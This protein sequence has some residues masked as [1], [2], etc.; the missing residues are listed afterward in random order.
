MAGQWCSSFRNQIHQD[1]VCQI[2]VLFFVQYKI[3]CQRRL[4]LA[5]PLYGSHLIL[6]N[7]GPNR[8]TESKTSKKSE[9]KCR[10][11]P[12]RLSMRICV[13]STQHNSD[14]PVSKYSVKHGRHAA[15]CTAPHIVLRWVNPQ[16]T[17]AWFRSCLF[18]CTL[19]ELFVYQSSYLSS[20]AENG[21]DCEGN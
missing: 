14:W 7:G 13:Y 16:C 3:I 2:K 10:G 1:Q 5:V 15:P 18:M 4:R 9:R 17:G 20:S 6:E 12:R 8:G 11:I 21:E 19:L